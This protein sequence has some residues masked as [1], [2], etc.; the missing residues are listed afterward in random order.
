MKPRDYA[1]IKYELLLTVFN[2]RPTIEISRKLGYEF[3]QAGRWLSGK[4]ELRWNE[5][6]E[7]CEVLNLPLRE[8][9]NDIFTLE[10]KDFDDCY[11]FLPKLK[12][13]L[14]KETLLTLKQK[15]GLHPSAIKRY[16]NGSVYASLEFIMALIDINANQLGSFLI[17]LSGK[18]NLT[19][20]REM[21]KEDRSLVSSTFTWPLA[22]AM[23]G[24]LA[25]EEYKSLAHHEPKW[26][27]YKLGITQEEYEAI[28]QYIVAQK[29]VEPEGVK[30]RLA[31]NTIN[32]SGQDID[33]YLKMM[34][35]WIKRSENILT[36]GK[37]KSLR[38]GNPSIFFSYRVVP[39]SQKKIEETNTILMDAYNKILAL[40]EKEDGPYTDV[41]VLLMQ[42]FSASDMHETEAT[43]ALKH[44]LEEEGAKKDRNEKDLIEKMQPKNRDIRR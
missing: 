32:T 30:F 13:F 40:A 44:M 2:H 25:T 43:L 37:N 10:F 42:C 39:M 28:W 9:L 17:Q 1:K 33:E 5:F 6:C 23:E 41:R 34:G 14:Q 38:K 7:L 20:L 18:N 35:F 21:F 26:F 22:S 29:R 4:K 24:L 12:S 31:Y 27:C 8:T 11:L 16:L 19:V 36:P 15:L 3:D